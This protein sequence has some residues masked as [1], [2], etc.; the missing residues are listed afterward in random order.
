MEKQ[1]FGQCLIVL[2]IL[3]SSSQIQGKTCNGL[4]SVAMVGCPEATDWNMP[5][6]PRPSEHC[7][8]LVRVIGMDCICEVVTKEMAAAID[9]KKLVSVAA[10]CG[11][12]LAPGSQC[13]SY[14]VP[15]A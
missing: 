9:M 15:S 4:G 13:G 2:M 7:C 10:T 5:N 12:P 3:L 14:Q 8:T 1:I 11:R 6:P